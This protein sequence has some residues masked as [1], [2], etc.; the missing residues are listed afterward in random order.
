MAEQ[1]EFETRLL[2]MNAEQRAIASAER[3]LE[4]QGI[5]AG[6]V[7]YEWQS[8]PASTPRPARADTPGNAPGAANARKPAASGH[9]H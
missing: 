9:Q 7:A 1:I 6:T 8:A 3:E 4:R 2:G 5:V